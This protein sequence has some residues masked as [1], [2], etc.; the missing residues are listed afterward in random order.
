MLHVDNHVQ[1][2]DFSFVVAPIKEQ[3]AQTP[4]SKVA[5][6]VLAAAQPEVKS[7][8]DVKIS[9][10]LVSKPITKQVGDVAKEVSLAL[11]D[12]P[13]EVIDKTAK[14]RIYKAISKQ[15]SEESE[16][17]KRKASGKESSSIFWAVAAVVA[18][19]VAV[20]ILITGAA[21]GV[22]FLLIGMAFIFKAY[23]DNAISEIHQQE[24]VQLLKDEGLRRQAS[25]DTGY[26]DFIKVRLNPEKYQSKNPAENDPK[27]R[28]E[29]YHRMVNDPR[30]YETYRE[31][32]NNHIPKHKREK[33]E[34]YLETWISTV[35]Q[36]HETESLV[37][38]KNKKEEIEAA[39]KKEDI[40]ARET[41]RKKAEE[42]GDA[43]LKELDKQDEQERN[44][45]KLRE[46]GFREKDVMEFCKAIN[47]DTGVFMSEEDYNKM[48]R[49]ENGDIH[50]EAF[51]DINKLKNPIMVG[52]KSG[53]QFRFFS[54]IDKLIRGWH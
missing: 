15:K 21:W 1:A 45:E 11:G 54:S 48:K 12:K 38:E 30:L 6:L 24:N 9:L 25:L 47:C 18:H 51:E 23:C 32:I 8:S 43:S 41:K 4:T 50:I 29:R 19:I 14:D 35:Y 28:E 52:G 20:A 2:P 3:A 22:S 49:G 7:E 16:E 39:K 46:M 17:L 44:A 36:L 42:S 5:S 53:E 40:I 10:E 26:D 33:A 31:S 27:H 34:A 37:Q 13:K